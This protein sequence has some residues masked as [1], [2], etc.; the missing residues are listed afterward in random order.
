MNLHFRGANS[1]KGY[2][3]RE[4]KLL[5]CYSGLQ[6]LSKEEKILTVKSVVVVVLLFYVHCKHLWSCRDRHLT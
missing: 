5:F 4:N 1:Y 3:Y 6:A 2:K